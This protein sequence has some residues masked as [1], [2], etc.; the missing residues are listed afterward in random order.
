MLAKRKSKRSGR[1]QRNLTEA[2]SA[3]KA[4]GYSDI[5]LRMLESE[6]GQLNAVFACYGS[7]AQHGQLFEESLTRLIVAL[8]EWSGIGGNVETIEKWTIGRLLG[9]LQK[10][11]VKEIDEWV[12]QYLEEGRRLRNFL[13]HDYFLRREE[14]LGTESGRM[15]MFEELTKIEQHLQRGADLINGLRVSIGRGMDGETTP[16]NEGSEVVFSAKLHIEKPER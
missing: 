5:S 6:E 8:N 4:L 14:Q 16:S 2:Q 9:H 11:F 15:A 13:I 3:Y 12:P 1:L 10:T 7:A